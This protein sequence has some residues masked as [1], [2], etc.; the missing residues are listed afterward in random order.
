MHCLPFISLF[1]LLGSCAPVAY[2]QLQETGG[3]VHCIDQFKP[4]IRRALY[5]TSADVTGHHLSG[6][7]LI[8]QMP[9]SATRIVFTNEAG[10]TFFDFEFDG[11][12][13]FTVHSIISKMDKEAVKRTL[14]KDFEL[15]LM[16]RLNTGAA[17]VFK[18]DNETYYAF[19]EGE[20][21]FYYIT[22]AQCSRLLRMERGN[23]RKK[24]L[25]ATRGELK[26]GIPEFIT[27]RHR[28]FNFTI[29]LKKIDDDAE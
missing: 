25:E 28:N 3:D 1:F 17:K 26:E 12:G 5:Q 9:D 8:K 24:V 7:L 13:S 23:T 14:R 2:R 21:V 10:Y 20:D 11:R 29:D 19:T 27:I 22:D 18:K 4:A 15:I 6:I 16:N